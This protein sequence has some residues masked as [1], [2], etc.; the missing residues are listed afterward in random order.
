MVIVA[1]VSTTPGDGSLGPPALVV[2]ISATYGAGGSII[3]P[4]VAERLGSRF[5][6]RAIPVA[7]AH[8]LAVPL[9]E[10]LEHDERAP[11]VIERVMRAMAMAGD[12]SGGSVSPVP[13]RSSTV[14]R[15]RTEQAIREFAKSGGGV[16]LGRAAAIVLAQAPNALHVRLDGPKRARMAQAM[17]NRGIDEATAAERLDE[18]DRARSA[19]VR[20]FYKVDASEARHYHLVIDSTAVPVPTCV[21]LIVLAA[22]A[23]AAAIGEG[24]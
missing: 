9:S 21:D 15:D 14:L 2:T 23:R 1:T 10:V 3:G 22:R 11:G 8:S 18:N 20:H 19:Y 7:V 16:I 12:P 5:L 13:V 17:R 24:S 6:D 4:A